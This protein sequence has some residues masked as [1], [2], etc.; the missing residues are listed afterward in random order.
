MLT[1]GFARYIDPSFTASMEE[2]LDE[3]ARGEKEWVPFL[4]EFYKPFEEAVAVAE[5]TL[6]RK[7][8]PSDEIC[9][10]DGKAM[11]VKSGR[12]GLFLACTGYPD[13]KG[14]KPL[15]VKVGVP[16]PEDA[17]EIV[18]KRSRKGTTFYGCANY[19][20]CTFATNLRPI[21]EPC[22]ECKGLLTA[23]PRGGVRCTK[24]EYKGKRP[25]AQDEDSEEATP[26]PEPVEAGY[27]ALAG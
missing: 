24:C 5:E 20:N 25:K 10:L 7:E 8:E 23:F 3:I 9:D 11:V 12:F 22:P 27:P 2:G 14:T 17:G 21:P 6:E 4:S 19:P 18:Q 16:C 13:C 15:Q 1:Q 26:Q